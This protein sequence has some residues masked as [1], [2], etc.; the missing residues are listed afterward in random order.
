MGRGGCWAR[1]GLLV[2]AF[3]LLPWQGSA[4]LAPN[5]LLAPTPRYQSPAPMADEI[6][7]ERAKRLAMAF[8]A[9]EVPV[10]EISSIQRFEL[11]T[12]AYGMDRG[13]VWVLQPIDDRSRAA[14]T[15]RLAACAERALVHRN[16]RMDLLIRLRPS[17]EVPA[18]TEFGWRRQPAGDAQRAPNPFRTQPFYEVSLVWGWEDRPSATLRHIQLCPP[19]TPQAGI[20]ACPA[21]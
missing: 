14:V 9:C 18:V 10:I 7:A 20:A 21:P 8:A 3:V 19:G 1:P 13:V 12:S 17:G 2:L 11:R 15:Q 6:R 16:V 5:D 4:Q